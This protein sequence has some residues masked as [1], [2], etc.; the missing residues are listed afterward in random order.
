V[1]LSAN[2]KLAIAKQAY[3]LARQE[4]R[5]PSLW[6]SEELPDSCA[7]F[8]W[9]SEE[10]PDSWIASKEFGTVTRESAKNARRAY[11]FSFHYWRLID[12]HEAQVALY[13]NAGKP[14]A[15][16]VELIAS[17]DYTNADPN[18][19]PAPCPICAARAYSKAGLP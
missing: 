8:L 13:A 19:A 11:P 18:V 10:L 14:L 2:T 15:F 16:A 7:P 4:D 3:F 9:K 12:E 17:H 6:K 1:T 5:A